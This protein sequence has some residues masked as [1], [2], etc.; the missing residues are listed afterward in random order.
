M[1]IEK[2]SLWQLLDTIFSR[3]LI[4]IFILFFSHPLVAMEKMADEQLSLI[5]GQALLQMGKTPGSGISSD[6]TFYKAGLEAEL[7]LNLNIEKLQLGCTSGG[8]I[9]GQNCDID[10]RNLGISGSPLSVNPDGTG[11]WANGRVGSSA[12]LTRP[13]FEFAIENDESKT[14]REVVGIRMSG[15]SITGLLTAGTQNHPVPVDDDGIQSL[16]GFMRIAQTMGEVTTQQGLFGTQPDELISGNLRANALVGNFDRSF[17]SIHDH[18]DTEGVTI[19]GINSGFTVPAFQVNG[20]RQTRASVS[21]VSTVIDEIPMN[22]AG[23]QAAGGTNCVNQLRV[24]LSSNI[25]TVSSSKVRLGGNSRLENLHL[26]ATFNQD[27][28]MIHNIPLS[29]TGM[30]LGFQ[31]KQIYW[32]GAH[33]GSGTGTDQTDIAQPG[34]WMSFQ[35]PVDLGYLQGAAPVDISDVFPQVAALVTQNLQQPGQRIE[36]E[37]G[38]SLDALTNSLVTPPN[39]VV[40]NLDSATNPALGGNPATIT[41]QNLQLVNQSVSSN[42]WGS[43]RFC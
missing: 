37:F 40:V 3:C 38:D 7:E 22:L 26:D 8:A 31:K 15:E 1:K 36:L 24:Q 10:I 25:L 4:T 9:N 20:K 5:S 12:I 34:W 6:L 33:I 17:T 14:L 11:N 29:G 27:L 16:S 2:K 41:L 42:C 30:Y 43:A 39:D 13:F 18:P 35:D 28:S 19:P 32:P 21:G 23:C